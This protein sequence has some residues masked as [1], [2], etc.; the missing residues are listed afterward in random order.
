[1][2][3]FVEVKGQNPK[4]FQAAGYGEHRPIVQNNSEAN[5]SRNRRVNILITGVEKERK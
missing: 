3:Y 4:R 1:M 5:R 2:K